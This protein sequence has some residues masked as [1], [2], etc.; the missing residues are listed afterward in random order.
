MFLQQRFLLGAGIDFF[1]FLGYAGSISF[2]G[3]EM[4]PAY[5]KKKY[6]EVF[7]STEECRAYAAKLQLRCENV[8]NE[9]TSAQ[10]IFDHPE[11]AKDLIDLVAQRIAE[12]GDYETGIAL[13]RGGALKLSV[14]QVVWYVAPHLLP[15][16]HEAERE[17]F[18]ERFETNP[19]DWWV[20]RAELTELL[21]FEPLVQEDP[22][23]SERLLSEQGFGLIHSK[24][25]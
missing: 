20:R 2:L 9:V 4:L 14:S 7:P 18:R 13:V 21:K 22:S 23:V 5:L 1:A 10:E 6:P 11:M 19:S 3:N 25:D 16:L 15:K 8:V 24:W 12:R 17:F